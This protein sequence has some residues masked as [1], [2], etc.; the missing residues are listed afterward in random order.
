MTSIMSAGMSAVSSVAEVLF[1]F[2]GAGLLGASL[3]GGRLSQAAAFFVMARY[4]G[5]AEMG[6]VAILTAF[7]L[8]LFQ[9][10]NLGFERYI[11]YAQTHD[12]RALDATI[13]AVWTMQLLRGIGV[14]ALILPLILLLAWF[15]GFRIG[16][17]HVLGI[18]AVIFILSL[19]NPELS[20]FERN[21]NFSSISLSRG[22]SAAFGAL[23][24]VLLVV[25]WHDPWV[26]VFG[27][28]ANGVALVAMS[29]YYGRRCPRLRFDTVRLR[30]VF[31]YGKHMVILATVSFLSSQGQNFY[32][33]IMFGASTL[34]AYYTWYRLVS[35]PGELVTQMQDR[36]LFAKASEQVRRQAHPGTTHL[37]GFA[38]SMGLLVPFY[39]LVW[40]QGDILMTFIAG[41]RWVPYWWIGKAFVLLSFFYAVAGTITPF[42]LVTVPHITSR[43]RS[44]EAICG[45]MLLIV[46]GHFYGI[47]GVLSALVIEIAV[48]VIL[49]ILILYRHIITKNRRDHAKSA[50]LIVIAVSAALLL[51]EALAPVLLPRDSP[52]V[53]V[54]VY[55]LYVMS[56]AAA[57]LASQKKIWFQE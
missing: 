33:G 41:E 11:V 27:Q 35:L 9:L 16:K 5:A 32:V 52:V 23:V 20:R 15:P 57:G 3:L 40:F 45:F 7:Y 56:L 10:T 49:R 34:G 1:R 36:L 14:L 39:I 43:L 26:Y 22:L 29:F 37:M 51:W 50:I 47:T 54:L 4:L 24:T 13:D 18:A 48:A 44:I 53:T 38:L 55:L 31:A 25:F 12:E 8:G 17:A 2:K 19:V 42:A 30:E 28:M 21:G 46:L 6:T